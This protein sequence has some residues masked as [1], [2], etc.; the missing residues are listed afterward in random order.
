[1]SEILKKITED[2][3]AAMKAGKKDELAVLRMLSSEAKNKRIE[4]KVDEITD[5][6]MLEVLGS[7]KKRRIEAADTYDKGGRAELAEKE[8][9]E[10]EVIERYLP[11]QLSD[12]ELEKVVTDAIAKTGASSPKDMGKVI[13]M[14]M[15]QVK[16]QA[17]GSRVSAMVKGKLTG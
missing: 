5:D 1:M 15:G 10:I 4:A 11:A 17:D 9:A 13:G 7:A 8:R 16:G 14:V 3:K 6:Q 12:E 2:T